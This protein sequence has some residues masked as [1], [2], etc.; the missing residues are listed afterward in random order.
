MT[1]KILSL[2]IIA[3]MTCSYA[4]AQ[5]L[6][7]SGQN[8]MNRFSVAP[9]F[10]GFNGNHEGFLG[11][12]TA[13]AGIDGA[14]KIVRADANGNI[15]GNMGYGVEISNEKSGN[16]T[17]TFA[18]ITYAYHLQLGGDANLSLAVSPAMVRSAYNL[19]GAKTFGA[20]TDPIFQNEAGMSATGFDAGFSLMLNVQ[21]LFFSI[22]APRLICPELKYQNGLYNYD[23]M[24]NGAVSYVLEQGK[25]EIEPMAQVK[26]LMESGLE[27]QGMLAAKYNRRAWLA[28]SYSSENWI[29]VGAGFAASNRIAVNYQYEM[30]TSDIAK[31]C[32]GTHEISVGFL[33]K[34]GSGY[35]KPSVFCEEETQSPKADNKL[36]DD[37]KRLEEKIN[38]LSDNNSGNATPTPEDNPNNLADAPA[39]QEEVETIPEKQL[40]EAPKGIPNVQF[41]YGNSTLFPSSYPGIDMFVEL[42]KGNNRRILITV[43]A[44]GTG[45]TKYSKELA[46]KRAESI[47]AY[48]VSKGISGDRIS[49]FGYK[50]H[51]KHGL[52]ASQLFQNNH[53]EAHLSK[54]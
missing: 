39:E 40:W 4:A 11:Y 36:R 14:P 33:I 30:G 24:I 50:E 5:D 42:M 18:A 15:M 13:M 22:N 19:G 10:A 43:Y 1:K 44:E 29:G 9:A 25:W 38:M 31:T 47:K 52:K 21:N 54:K 34:K 20:N 27:W 28:V 53:A 32:N 37:I 46:L 41:G 26:Y 23:R 35:K 45:S 7:A 2:A 6:T 51:R 8:Y 48:M 16:F 3:A 17:N 49:T 12:R